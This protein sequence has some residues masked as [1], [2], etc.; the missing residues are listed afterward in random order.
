MVF[1]TQC[2]VPC[3]GIINLLKTIKNVKKPHKS[4]GFLFFKLKSL[5]L[6]KH[7]K[8][9]L[10]VEL[11]TNQAKTCVFIKFVQFAQKNTIYCVCA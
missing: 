7:N 11:L 9:W 3:G 8:I 10:Q 1:S 2:L 6:Y 5:I 4:R